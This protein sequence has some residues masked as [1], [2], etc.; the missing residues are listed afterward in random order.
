MTSAL[1]TGGNSSNVK[2]TNLW[3]TGLDEGTY[4]LSETEAPQGYSKVSDIS[5]TLTAVVDA[6][7]GQKTGAL[8]DTTI[9]SQ[10]V[11]GST[12]V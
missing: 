12:G 2:A 11:V 7:T 5:I 8:A 1:I 6:T 4:T 9:S 3:M 10:S